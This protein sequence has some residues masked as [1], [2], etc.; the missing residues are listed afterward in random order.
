MQELV[1]IAPLTEEQIVALR[2]ILKNDL[3]VSTEGL[4]RELCDGSEDARS[5]AKSVCEAACLLN[6]VGWS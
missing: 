4:L 5:F 2:D 3:M 6:A 1:G